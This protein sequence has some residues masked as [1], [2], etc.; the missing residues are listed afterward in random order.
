[1]CVCMYV[2]VCLCVW[3]Y[4]CMHVYVC[5]CMDVYGCVC[6]YRW[7]NRWVGRQLAGTANHTVAVFTQPSRA[8]SLQC[9]IPC[10]TR[11]PNFC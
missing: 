8:L 10:L 4:V 6:V 3:M 2:C 1:M 9:S 11:P 7:L 5:V